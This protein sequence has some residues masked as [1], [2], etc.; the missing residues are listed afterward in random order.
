MKNTILIVTA[1]C[2]LAACSAPGPISLN[3]NP[4]ACADEK[5]LWH[6]ARQEQLKI[7]ASGL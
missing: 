7:D 2:L 5:I 4:A 3:E 1:L 6:N